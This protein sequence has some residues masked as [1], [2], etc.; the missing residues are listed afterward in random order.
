MKVSEKQKQWQKAKGLETI[1]KRQRE[2]EAGKKQ[3][4]VEN[5]LDLG[6]NRIL[7]VV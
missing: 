3:H 7:L 4:V 1:G 6:L 2:S 5:A